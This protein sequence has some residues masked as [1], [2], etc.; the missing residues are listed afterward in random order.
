MFF[1]FL[2]QPGLFSGG[3][4][5]PPSLTPASYQWNTTRVS[6]L[7][8]LNLPENLLIWLCCAA[9]HACGPHPVHRACHIVCPDKP[10]EWRF[11]QQMHLSP[12][13]LQNNQLA[14]QVFRH[15]SDSRPTRSLPMSLFPFAQIKLFRA[16]VPLDVSW[17]IR[18]KTLWKWRGKK[19]LWK[20]ISPKKSLLDTSVQNPL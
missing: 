4:P 3:C 18:S 9:S 12:F 8:Q 15:D 16:A 20:W 6:Q 19:R 10:Q 11:S 1:F 14:F 5:T 7:S 17:G 2:S 13:D